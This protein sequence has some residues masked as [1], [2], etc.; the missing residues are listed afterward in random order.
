MI[1]TNPPFG[2]KLP[3]KDSDT[4]SQYD[5]GHVWRKVDGVWEATEYLQSSQ[6]PEILFIERCWQFLKPS[7]RMAIVLPDAILGAPGLEYVRQWIMTHCRLVASIDLHPDTFQPGNGTQTSVMILQRKS[8]E[9]TEREAIQRKLQDYEIFMAQVMAMGHDKRGNL[10]YKRNEDGELILSPADDKDQTELFEQTANGDV[11]KRP[12]ARQKI[13]DDDSP[14]V[15][16]EF[17]GWKRTAV[18]GW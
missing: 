1:A 18:L 11:T 13:L 14:L 5:L 8:E 9:D 4:L 2:S 15:A 16:K 7:G 17:L 12:I 10:T 6:P 3:I